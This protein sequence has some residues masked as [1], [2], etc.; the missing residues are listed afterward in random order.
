VRPLD[1][2][3]LPLDG[4]RLLEASAGTGKTYTLALLF[5]RLLLERGL[6]ID[7]IL[8]VTFT[9]AATAELR[10]R[11][12][13]RLR[14][15]LD[16]LH[17][18]RDA[19]PLLLR[20]LT[21]LPAARSRQRL[22][23]ALVRMDEAAIHTIHGFCQRILR[24]HAFESSL[25][26]D[27]EL[28]ESE[29]AL[30]QEVLE[31]FWRTHLYPA[32]E[33]EAAWALATWGGPAGLL[34]GLGK[35]L[36]ALRCDLIPQVEDA[37]VAS[38]AAR[39]RDVFAQVREAWERQRA[40]VACLLEQD[41]SLLRNQ[42]AYRH[43][44]VT[45]LL[46]AMDG[47]AAG[48]VM[49]YLLPRIV[50][51]MAASVMATLV[52]KKSAG[53]PEHPFFA[54]FDTFVQDHG[55][56][57]R[58][59]TIQVLT[60]ARTF[61]H[62]ERSRRKRAQGWL[63]FDDL[64]TRLAEALEQPGSG[65]QLAD[66]VAA[67]YPAALVDEFQ[68]TD[69]VQY[70]VFSRIYR[71]ERP[72]GTALFLIGDPKQAIYSFRGA[73]IFTYI[74]ARRETVPENRY[75]MGTNYRS[76]PAMVGAVNALFGCRRDAFVFTEDIDFQPV[77][78]ATEARAEPLLLDG[79][80]APP[81]IGLL[82]DSERLKS[83]RSTT[84]SKDKALR[85][86]VTVCSNTIVGLLDQARLGQATIG[87]QALQTSDIAILV[88]SHREAEAMQAG[89]RRRGVNSLASSQASVFAS[90][91]ARQLALVL[92]ALVDPGDP[93]RIRTSLATDL[94][95][96]NA[97][98]LHALNSDERAW[99]I[100][101]AD[102]HRYRQLWQE[103]GIMPML[104]QLLAQEAVTR[105]LSARVGG[106][107]SLTNFLHLAELLQQ[108]PAGRHGMA[109]LLRWFRQQIDHPDNTAADQLIRLENDEQLIRIVTIHRA[110]GLEFPVVFLPFPWA[111]RGLDADQPLS[112]HERDSLGLTL[113]LGTG[114]EEHQR[115]AEQEQLAEELRLLYVAVTRA[116]SCCLFCWGRVNGLERSGLAYLLH[117][118]RCPESD[119]QL[120]QE[121]EQLGGA[122]PLVGLRP[123]PE[124]FGHHR[125]QSDIDLPMPQPRLFR[126]RVVPG[127][128]ITSY[129]RLASGSDAALET[130]RDE[131]AM[132]PSEEAA[133]G[134]S[135]FTFP[136]GAASGTCLHTLLQR[137]ECNHPVEGQQQLVAEVL[138]QGGI[139]ARWQATAVRWL[140]A[141]LAVELPGACSLNQVPVRD[142]IN[143]LGFL[144]PLEKVDL[145]R[146]NRLLDGAGLRPLTTPVTSLQGLMKGF[147]DLVFR[148]Q[149]RYWIVDYKSNHLGPSLAHYT[150]EALAECM[151]SHQYHLQALVYTLALHRFL[152]ARIADYRYEQHVGG[153]YYLFLRAMDPAHP[154]GSGV[155]AFRPD[156]ALIEALDD[157][158]RGGA[159]R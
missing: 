70:Q 4:R 18:R 101:L 129:S 60:T 84:I 96:C 44:Q 45:G 103:Q 16:V 107:R 83:T 34:K 30:V 125:F 54:L 127:W 133:S 15:A 119:A 135:P 7:Q 58:C 158:C 151:D 117:R 142:R 124:R 32:S 74:R 110:K 38:L 137:L 46:A 139:E 154:P 11:I 104:Q 5:V 8:V 57:L 80:P 99:E 87:G 79:E 13:T 105:R 128:T 156:A 66:R 26:F 138:E 72:A 47:L 65:G 6:A 120:C 126:G 67:R 27:L 153:V 64:L 149:G 88:R 19:D 62:Q 91:E 52:K 97:G 109:A 68:D 24:D 157:C 3:T 98:Q 39:A 121:L 134:C 71:Q 76:T 159:G 36:T 48:P 33:E 111:G 73:D 155:H 82:L 116:K 148:F 141:V 59:R 55:R 25:P 113:D 23:D 1:P 92:A 28:R 50:A 143:E 81:L 2:L 100:R 123:F 136:R 106:E 31:D 20:L 108:S 147:I 49:P 112:F 150:P 56:F 61:V 85:A 152:D 131:P 130:D 144:F 77:Q 51:R 146:F 115:W 53:P 140:D 17:G 89:L 43:D 78:A 86:A 94:F 90:E 75:T 29:A 40:Q 102:V 10:D 14:E 114:Q 12:R 35:A 22:E 37:E 9:R 132:A 118:A 41:S 95:G 21:A 63:A 93:A 42:N 122:Q 69:P 145:R